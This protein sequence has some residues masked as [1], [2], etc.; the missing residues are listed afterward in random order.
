M[1]YYLA[2]LNIAQMK[3]PLDDPLMKR[4]VEWLEPINKLA[5]ESPGFIWRLQ[6]DEGDAT[7]IRAFEDELMLVNM[8]VWE[9]VE[10]LKSYVFDSDHVQV[11][12]ERAQ[13]FEQM[14]TPKTVL[15][16]IPKG[17]IPT[18]EE[19]KERLRLL[20]EN[21]VCE[22]AFTFSRPFPLPGSSTLDMVSGDLTQ[23]EYD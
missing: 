17:H 4:F 9:S 1:E 2:Q 6:S 16:W 11:M 15:W 20:T 22:D 7:S 19:A 5:D 23:G 3:A 10:A 13:W 8:S 14:D 18:I 21:G 12:R